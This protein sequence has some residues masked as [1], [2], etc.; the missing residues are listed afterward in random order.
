M[1]AVITILGTIG[2]TFNKEIKKYEVKEDFQ[3]SFYHSDEILIKKEYYTNVFPLLIDTF[4]NKYEIVPIFTKESKEVQELVLEKLENKK[5]WIKVFENGVFI[6]NENEFNAIFKAIDEKLNKYDKVIIDVSHGFRHLPIL[7]LID[8][9]VQNIKYP[10]KIEKI[11]FAKEEEKNKKYK[12]IDLIEYLDLANITYVLSTFTKNYTISS[13]IKTSIEEYNKFLNDLS[14][15]SY[16][17]LANSLKEL[18]NKSESLI[19]QIEN[20]IKGEKKESEI[21]IVFNSYLEEIK[22]HMEKIMKFS[23]EKEDYKR[24]YYF[25]KNMYEKGYLLNAITLLSEANGMY[26]AEEIFSKDEE[27]KKYIEEYKNNPKYKAYELANNSKNIVKH[28]KNYKGYY[29]F[30]KDFDLKNEITNKLKD[31]SYYEGFVKFTWDVDNLRNNL[32]HGNSSESIEDVKSEIQNYLDE[33]KKITNI[34][35]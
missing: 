35:D 6:E 29:L 9:L 22:S 31:K 19:E 8:V 12:I 13:N 5:K 25:S 14:D 28:N 16:H 27:V 24:L 17:I 30:S 11:L 21:F 3:K 32:A 26:I 18:K 2:G 7:M 20:I 23:N 33:F 10:E 4:S 1:K 34:K 15:F